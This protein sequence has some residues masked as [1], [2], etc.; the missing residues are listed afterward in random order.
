MATTKPAKKTTTRRSTKNAGQRRVGRPAVRAASRP[1]D[2]AR[3]GAGRDRTRLQR[4]PRVD[5]R[6]RRR[7]PTGRAVRRHPGRDGRVRDAHQL[8]VAQVQWNDNLAAVFTNPGNVNGVRWGSGTMIGPDLFLTCGHLFDPDINGWTVPRQ[9]GTANAI[10]PQQAATNMHLN[11]EYQVDAS[12]VL[13][14]EQSFPITQLIEYRL[15]GLDMALCRIGGNPGPLRVE[16]VRDHER[17]RRRHARHH[18]T[19]GRPAQADRGRPG[20]LPSGSVIQYN[21]IDTLGGNS[22]SG[23]LQARR[24]GSSA[25]TPTAGATA[26][27]PAA[28]PGS[29]SPRSSL[30]PR[31]CRRR[32][33]APRPA[34][35]GDVIATRLSDDVGRHAARRRHRHPRPDRDTSGRGL[36]RHVARPRLRRRPDWRRRRGTSAGLRRRHPPGR[37]RR[38]HPGRQRRSQPDPGQAIVDLD[39]L[40]TDPAVSPG[41]PR[42]ASGPSCR[43]APHLGIGGEATD[44]SAGA[45][46]LVELERPSGRMRRCWSRW[47][48]CTTR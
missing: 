46:V 39:D 21:D 3:V 22:G 16:R 45:A 14:A 29:R 37:G 7:L 31:R 47:R 5:L 6:R 48:R 9:N 43:P 41:S 18:R 33:R 15:G 8:P 44:R 35:A 13:R 28:T 25:C 1:A 32:H 34:R 26:R 20:H 12:S 2:A 30:R 11:F 40:W 23:I 19:P 42:G 38:R 24:A 36:P 10:S 17:R 27:A 4:H